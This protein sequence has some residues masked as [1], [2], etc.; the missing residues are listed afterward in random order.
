MIVKLV[1]NSQG[2]T[3]SY[4]AWIP[5]LCAGITLAIVYSLVRRA[6]FWQQ[7]RFGG[8]LGALFMTL[9]A[10]YFGS[11]KVSFNATGASLYAFGR[12]NLKVDWLD[13][14]GVRLERAHNRGRVGQVLMIATSSG[15]LE[16]NI[17]DLNEDGLRHLMPYIEAQIGASRAMKSHR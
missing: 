4:A 17:S 3:L 16:F 11:Y 9:A 8:Y 6:D 13:V 10:L 5:L 14:S 15:E 12:Y 1:Q 7:R 2:I